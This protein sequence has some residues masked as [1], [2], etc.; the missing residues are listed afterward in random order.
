M[1]FFLLYCAILPLHRTENARDW[2][3]GKFHQRFVRWTRFFFS[4]K[5]QIEFRRGYVAW[6]H[7]WLCINHHPQTP[8]HPS[9]IGWYLF[10]WMCVVHKLIPPID[11]RTMTGRIPVASA[12]SGIDIGCRAG[13]RR[14]YT[15]KD[16]VHRREGENLIWGI[17]YSYWHIWSLLVCNF[18]KC[19]RLIQSC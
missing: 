18:V 7:L 4:V 15:S 5:P 10:L 1:F 6:G 9:W 8:L 14:M 17:F 16:F 11:E 2:C 12:E 3:S 19:D 13:W